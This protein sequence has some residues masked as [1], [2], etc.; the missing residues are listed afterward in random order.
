MG[1]GG[2]GLFDDLHCA[3]GE[4]DDDAGMFVAVHGERS[5]R[6]NDGLPDFDVVV[7][8]LRDALGLR[9]LGGER[10]RWEQEHSGKKKCACEE[11]KHEFL[12]CE[13]SVRTKK[14]KDNAESQRAQ[15]FAER[16]DSMKHG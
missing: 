9:G 7:F 2:A 16:S 3:A 8:E 15:R 5:V 13:E 1:F 10:G 6:K 14:E 11:F 4:G 12:R